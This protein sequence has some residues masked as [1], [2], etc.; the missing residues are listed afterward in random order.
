M[1]RFVSTTT[2]ETGSAAED[3]MR[4]KLAEGFTA[5]WVSV[6]DVSGEKIK[7]FLLTYASHSCVYSANFVF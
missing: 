3:A 6:K 2:G 7:Q 1:M 4:E 5:E